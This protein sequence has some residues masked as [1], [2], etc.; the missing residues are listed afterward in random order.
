MERDNSITW[1]FPDENTEHHI[2][3]WNEG[4]EDPLGLKLEDEGFLRIYN[5][6]NEIFQVAEIEYIGNMGYRGTIG[7]FEGIWPADQEGKASGREKGYTF[8]MRALD[9]VLEAYIIDNNE[10]SK[11]YGGDLTA[12]KAKE[13]KELCSQDE[14]EDMELDVRAAIDADIDIV[15]GLEPSRGEIWMERGSEKT[16]EFEYR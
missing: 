8:I 16:L 2:E 7:P 6:S 4:P 14:Y 13:E 5:N 11:D 12:E 9:D 3:G 15:M 1:E 10:M